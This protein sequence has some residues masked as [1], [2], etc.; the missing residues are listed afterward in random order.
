MRISSTNYVGDARNNRHSTYSSYAAFF[1]RDGAIRT[2][3]KDLKIL[4]N[5][6]QVRFKPDSTTSISGKRR[7]LFNQNKRE[8]FRERKPNH[9]SKLKI[10]FSQTKK[11]KNN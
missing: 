10:C 11:K 1:Y 9:V 5:L 8:I 6:P 3:K 7:S 2:L 4:R